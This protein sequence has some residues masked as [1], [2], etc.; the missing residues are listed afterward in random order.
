MPYDIRTKD[1]FVIRN[2]PDDIPPDH[3][4]LKQRVQFLRTADKT[5]VDNEAFAKEVSDP[6]A[7]MSF[8]DKLRAGAGK[9][10]SDLASGA[11]QL[12]GAGPSGEEVRETKQ[13]DQA[14]MN[15][16][17]GAIGNIGANVVTLAPLAMVP[18]ANTVA[19]AGAI[20][21]LTGMLQPAENM[22]DR[23]INMG[24][25]GALGSGTQ[26]LGTTGAQRLGE[27]GASRQAEEAAK[28]SRNAVAD[29]TL[30]MG[31]EAGYKLP[32]SAV[33][34]SFIARR[35]EGV[36]GKA[37]VGQD[38]S[39]KNIGVT[40]TLGRQAAGISPE[41]A[42]S[43]QNIRNARVGPLAQPYRDVAAL[44]PRA[45]AD[46][47]AMKQAQY[48]AKLQ[49]KFY[50]RSGNPEALTAAKTAETNKARLYQN[51]VAE[52]NT[53]GK[54][55]L[56]PALE[57]AKKRIAQNRLIQEAV[58]RGSGSIDPSVIGRAYDNGAPL[59]GPLETIARMQQAYPQYM[60]EAAKVPTPG[61]SKSEALA[62]ALLATTGA[63]AAGPFGALAGVA[64]FVAPPVAR[65]IL[66]S[67]PVQE[68]VMTPTYNPGM[69][70]N[71]AANLQDP[72][73]RQKL[74]NVL[75]A[76]SFSAVP[77]VTNQ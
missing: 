31:R 14:L 44:S 19:G 43:V 55:E 66:R 53:A 24:T 70:A 39:L 21:A 52:A 54:P 73:V 13:R 9:G 22:T 49:H 50:G 2:I 72:A 40:D 69:L 74:A 34:D 36:G 47:E 58:N 30:R 42:L 25:G 10:F 62:S 35:L 64:P 67:N 1:G 33:N 60:R 3:E 45:A 18:G 6:T 17:P 46:L 15:T 26:Y 11:S 57:E 37:A 12:V 63:T 7:G 48:D 56:I 51:L 5:R 38:F 4:S 68:A 32:P 8:L 75:R 28:Q 76:L 71:S 65:S 20:G 61:V 59:S 41:Q 77:E 16:A 29:E 23:A 27:W